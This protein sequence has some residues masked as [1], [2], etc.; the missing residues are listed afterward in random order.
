MDRITALIAEDEP[1]L[2]QQL[3]QMLQQLWPELIIE[4][5]VGDGDSAL[6]RFEQQPVDIA[7]LD[8]R[9]P[10]LDGLSVAAKLAGRCHIVFVTAYDQYA[11]EAF[12]HEAIDYL[13]KPI[14]EE[15]LQ[16]SIER[17]QKRLQQHPPDGDSLERMLQLLHQQPAA[18]R[19]EPLKWIR[20]LKG[21][22]IHL[23]ATADVLYFQAGD[24]YTTVVTSA[25]E[26]LIRKP[27]KELESEL[28]SELFWRI[29]RSTIVNLDA[30][31]CSQRDLSGGYTLSLK[32]SNRRL[33]VSRGYAHLF[34]QM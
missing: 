3:K 24:K 19:P 6:E 10:G 16:Q 32:G 22:E 15:R 4:A 2:R 5:E 29:H 31:E 25:A 13:L 28:N 30:V 34:K 11:V 14:S 23:I 27:V 7:F 26:Y 12:E 21:E 33:K 1:A 8:I 20:A 9:M 18:T 17:I